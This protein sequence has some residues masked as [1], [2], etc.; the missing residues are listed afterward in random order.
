MKTLFALLLAITI[1]LAFSCKKLDNLTQFVMTFEQSCTIPKSSSIN[2]PF[3]VFTPDVETNSEATFSVENT[4]K[5]LVEKILL[6]SLKLSITSPDGKN[7]SFLKSISIYLSAEGIPETKIAWKDNINKNPGSP[8]TLELS[9]DDLKEF[10]KKD[11]FSLRLNTVT[12]E[13]LTSDYEIKV[14]SVFF[15]DAKVLGQ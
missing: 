7:F 13:F 10:I 1:P 9:G 4:R 6:E 3:N 14:T 12:D 2:L 11:R 5:D 15:V 8:V